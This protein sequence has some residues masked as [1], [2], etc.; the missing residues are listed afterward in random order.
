MR[1]I[2][3]ALALGLFAF[4]PAHALL[5]DELDAALPLDPERPPEG[6]W[7]MIRVTAG[8]GS[9][10]VRGERHP[11]RPTVYT[12]A[13]PASE[14]DLSED[15]RA[16]W[17]SM[18]PQP[19]AQERHEP[20]TQVS[21]SLDPI[22]VRALL[23]GEARLLREADGERVYGFQPAKLDPMGSAPDFIDRF[24]GEVALREGAVSWMRI[25]A[26]RSFKPSR[27]VRVTRHEIRM[28]YEPDPRFEMPVM[29]SMRTMVEGSAMFQ[30]F[31]Q[32][33]TMEILEYHPGDDAPL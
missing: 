6:G 3:A 23:G 5:P 7:M 20:R 26:R 12:L 16:L 13:E 32:G 27:A 19:D 25:Y 10:T 29:R 9:V 11:E 28:D 21:L 8:E 30:S 24:S 2:L 15:Q 17:E 31:E 4:T 18:R 14:D 1:A 22:T 33:M